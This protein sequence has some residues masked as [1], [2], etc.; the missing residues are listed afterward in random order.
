ML[1]ITHYGACIVLKHKSLEMLEEIYSKWMMQLLYPMA[2]QSGSCLK[3]S[4]I[5]KPLRVKYGGEI[6]QV[7][8]IRTNSEKGNWNE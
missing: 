6:L 8:S 3:V 1:K 5:V 4:L 2:K 7:Q